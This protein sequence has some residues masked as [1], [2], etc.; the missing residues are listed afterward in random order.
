MKILAFAAASFA[1][2][3]TASA[4]AQDDTRPRRT[5]I[6]LGAQLVPNYPGADSVA[7][8]PFPDFSRARGDDPFDFE[9][10]DES[11]GF[12]VWRADGLSVG[13][14]L[15]FEG[16]R[17]RADTGGALAPVGVSFEVGGF[18]QYQLA[19]AL[20]LRAEARQGFGGHGGLVANLSADYIL[21][22][23]DRWLFS[24]GPRVTL[25]SGKYQRA[26]FG[27][28]PRDAAAAGIAAFRPDGG[29]Q[30][31]GA[32]AG[33]IKQITPRWGVM[34]YAKY[35]RLVDG[36]GR[37]PAVRGFGSRNQI[38]GGVAATYTFGVGRD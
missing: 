38:S 35:D 30:A 31:V 22:D 20:R 28:A 17:T 12:P 34:G 4:Q 6:A 2:L 36:A 33:L 8:R 24:L 23:G 18:A 14:A 9:A 7:V 27:V 5:R 11:F 15:G 3:T 19:P 16:R 10:A 21:R 37:S 1:V 26:Y 25:T 13:P 32:A 29:L